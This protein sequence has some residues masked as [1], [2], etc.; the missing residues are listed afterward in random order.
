MAVARE[1]ESSRKVAVARETESSKKVAVAWETVSRKGGW[2]S[3]NRKE[4]SWL[5]KGKHKGAELAEK[6]ET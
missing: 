5:E 2:S 4:Q 6:G 3:G 1:T